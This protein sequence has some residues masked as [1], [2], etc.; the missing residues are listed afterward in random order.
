MEFI[1]GN[2]SEEEWMEV[3]DDEF[4]DEVFV[5]DNVCNNGVG[6]IEG[7]KGKNDDGNDDVFSFVVFVVIVG[8]VV[9]IVDVKD[10]MFM[11]DDDRWD[12]E[13]VE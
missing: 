11:L 1:V 8:V 2:L 10:C 4:N 3:E 9:I 6:E 12:D 5:R 7:D 13:F